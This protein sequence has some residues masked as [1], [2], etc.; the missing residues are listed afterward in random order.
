MQIIKLAIQSL[1]IVDTSSLRLRNVGSAFLK[2][3][4]RTR[5]SWPYYLTKL[6][7]DFFNY[8]KNHLRKQ[9]KH[10]EYEINHLKKENLTNE[11]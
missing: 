2:N 9:Y 3:A 4:P 6:L 5:K 10:A 7:D 11:K 1:G 8:D